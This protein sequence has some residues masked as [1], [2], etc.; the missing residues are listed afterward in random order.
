MFCNYGGSK[1]SQ[2]MPDH[3]VMMHGIAQL[4]LLGY[5]FGMSSAGDVY[6]SLMLVSVH[7]PLAGCKADQQHEGV[8][9]MT[10]TFFHYSN[11]AQV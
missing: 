6:D 1:Y 4:A 8:K 10:L 11:D 7:R 9:N 3:A 2:G 5:Y